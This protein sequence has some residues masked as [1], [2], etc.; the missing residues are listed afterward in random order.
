M[1]CVEVRYEILKS[2]YFGVKSMTEGLACTL[3][4]VSHVIF[5]GKNKLF[6]STGKVPV[7]KIIK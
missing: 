7:Y 3:V 5:C 1:P 6:K 4:H 2:S